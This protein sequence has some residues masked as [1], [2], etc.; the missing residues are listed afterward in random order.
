[1]IMYV[2]TAIIFVLIFLNYFLGFKLY[3]E[4]KNSGYFSNVKQYSVPRQKDIMT[5]PKYVF[6]ISVSL[7]IFLGI[8]ILLGRISA[9]NSLLLWGTVL[10]L[11]ILYLI[12]ITR[13]IS[14]TDEYLKFERAFF[15]T[16]KIMLQQID[17]I[18]VYSYNKRFINKN[19]FTTKLVVSTGSSKYKFTLSG[20][21]TRSVLNMMKENF[22][23]S[24]NKMYIAHN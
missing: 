7:G 21:D 18:Y 4:P 9:M 8:Y 17:G 24:E 20:I 22:G 19:A 13:K 3:K 23:I 1:M 16:K 11:F 6:F 10:V 15:K 14:L 5:S 12:E 2:V